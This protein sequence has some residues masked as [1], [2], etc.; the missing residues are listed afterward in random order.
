MR[1]VN[2]EG[3]VINIETTARGIDVPSER[4]LSV[5]T[6]T[7]QKR[8]L[9]EVIGLA[10]MNQAAVFWQKEDHQKALSLYEKAKPFFKND[11]LLQLFL[12]LNYLF[13]GKEKE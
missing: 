11:Y 12:G 3:E 2:T 9:H 10:F 6:K 1:H 7:L 13:I 8:N 5:D 4:Y